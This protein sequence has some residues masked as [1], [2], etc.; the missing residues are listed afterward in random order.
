MIIILLII[1]THS[2]F[3]VQSI[4]FLQ[5]PLIWNLNT[6]TCIKIFI[7]L[8]QISFTF[9]LGIGTTGEVLI[10]HNV[11]R[12]CDGTYEC[13]AYNNVEPAVTRQIKVFV[14]CKYFRIMTN[15]RTLTVCNKVHWYDMSLYGSDLETQHLLNAVLGI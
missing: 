15:I 14:E 7:K 1:M 3:A 13:V 6:W 9:I 12:Y 11:S 5:L 2:N 4:S 10:I 8:Q